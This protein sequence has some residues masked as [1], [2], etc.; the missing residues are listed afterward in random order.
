[1]INQYRK[2]ILA[3]TIVLD[4]ASPH[5]VRLPQVFNRRNPQGN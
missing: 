4:A 1:M 2:T 3:G 5:P